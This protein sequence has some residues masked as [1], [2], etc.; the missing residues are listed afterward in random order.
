[1]REHDNRLTRGLFTVDDRFIRGTTAALRSWLLAKGSSPI[2]LCKLSSCKACPGITKIQKS[3]IINYLLL[4]PS[5]RKNPFQSSQ[6]ICSISA[7]PPPILF[8]FVD[9]KTQTYHGRS[10]A[11]RRTAAERAGRSEAGRAEAGQ[12]GMGRRRVGA[13]KGQTSILPPRRRGQPSWLPG[14]LLRGREQTSS[15]VN[16]IKEHEDRLTTD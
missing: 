4:E 1:M 8:S 5:K 10:G 12:G 15:H 11:G 16:R 14:H 13:P 9:S 6:N 2:C 3:K 7:K